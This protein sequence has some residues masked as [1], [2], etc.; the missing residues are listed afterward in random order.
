[1][2]LN[3]LGCPLLVFKKPIAKPIPL[4]TAERI[5]DRRHVIQVAVI[6]FTLTLLSVAGMVTIFYS[7]IALGDHATA[8]LARNIG[9][10]GGVLGL[11]LAFL[12][13]LYRQYAHLTAPLYA[14]AGGIFMTGI[15]LHF[16]IRFPGIALQSIFLTLAVFCIMLLLYATGTIAVTRKLIIVIYAATASIALAYLFSFL[17]IFL[18]FHISFLHGAGTGGTIWFGFI[19]VTA[20]INMVLDFERINQIEGRKQ[21]VFMPW[22]VGLGLMITMVWLYV[23]ILRMLATVRR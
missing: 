7:A 20:A 14:L 3:S 19:A 8:E 10:G 2:S 5:M 11:S 22:Y 4:G 17:L 18:D 13:M 6:L 21:P 1:M 9:F 15:A 16:E 12:T 23:S